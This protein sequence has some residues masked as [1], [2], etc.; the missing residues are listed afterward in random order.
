MYG[1]AKCIAWWDLVPIV[2][3]LESLRK[4]PDGIETPVP[5]C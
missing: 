3:G 2:F 1:I 4:V 5:L